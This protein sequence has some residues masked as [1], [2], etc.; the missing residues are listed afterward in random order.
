[1]LRRIAVPLLVLFALF[2]AV[3][4]AFETSP[5]FRTWLEDR[6]DR[7]A[8]RAPVAPE[9]SGRP[10]GQAPT[11]AAPLP[12]PAGPPTPAVAAPPH[13]AEEPAAAPSAAGSAM[14]PAPSPP[15]AVSF[16]AAPPET[17][18][19]PDQRAPETPAGVTATATDR[20]IALS[21]SESRDDRGVVA[22][23]VHRDGALV[24][25]TSRPGAVESGLPAG[26]VYCYVVRALD[27]AGNTSP[28]SE[29]A[30]TT[31]PDTTPPA[32]PTAL[33]VE[34]TGERSV[35]LRWSPAQD[36]VAVTSYEVLRDGRVVA[37]GP[38]SEATEDGLT[39]LGTVCYEVV[40]LDAAANRST[41]S[42]RMCATLPDLTPPTPPTVVM[43]R[44]LSETSAALSWSGATD[45]GG[46]VSYDLV[47]SGSIVSTTG[48]ARAT[49]A[50]LSAGRTFCWTVRARDPA[51]NVSGDSA[52]ACTTT[53]DHTPP[54]PPPGVVAAPSSE[55]RVA[56]AWQP[57]EDNVGVERYE[58]Y[59]DGRVVAKTAATGLGGVEGGLA[60]S[61]EYC[62]TVV[63]VDGAGNRSAPAAPACARTTEPGV[64]AGPTALRATP[65]AENVV[66]LRWDSSP[67]RGMVYAVYWDG[68]RRIGATPRTEYTVAGLR[69]GEKRCYRVAAVN[70]A[71]KESPR[72]IEA[73]AAPGPRG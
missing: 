14:P 22:Y 36:D 11:L 25:R 56:F 26:R 9:A 8:R 40:A 58:V 27:A 41:S 46:V 64:P 39:P 55:S 71:G 1:V 43:A 35:R 42:S 10:A 2:L 32:A 61:T 16:E 4:H 17:V 51:G 15:S 29:P 68:D 19:P 63:A 18:G 5:R 13:A 53:P 33:V 21:W 31:P 23:Q 52:R 60:P 62:F 54:G 7:I 49:D 45:A 50:D 70:G 34:A 38:A 65:S 3:A 47:R 20:G 12:S 57:A 66:V 6:F 59:R 69:P 24:A 73:C 37:S 67:E 28:D 72:S 44:P 48:S 30:C